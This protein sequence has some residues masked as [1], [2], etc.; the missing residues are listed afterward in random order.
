MVIH[1]FRRETTDV[2]EP[3]FAERRSVL[4]LHPLLPEKVRDV[5]HLARCGVSSGIVHVLKSIPGERVDRL[6]LEAGMED[7]TPR[8]KHTG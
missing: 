5:A 3:A 6:R 1:G 8:Q 4:E 2:G 7:Q